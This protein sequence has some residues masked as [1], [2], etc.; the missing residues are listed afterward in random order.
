MAHLLEVVYKHDFKLHQFMHRENEYA[1]TIF[2]Y[3]SSPMEK[4][5]SS[6]SN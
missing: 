2:N 3:I 4:Y 5:E 1:S 6:F